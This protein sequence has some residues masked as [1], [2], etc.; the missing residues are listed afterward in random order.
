MY[1]A[2]SL[3]IP[4]FEMPDVLARVISFN[5]PHIAT[6]SPLWNW[7]LSVYLVFGIVIIPGCYAYWVYPY[8]HGPAWARGLI[9]GGFLWF[10]VEMWFMPLIGQN[11][12]DLSGSSPA[13]EILSQLVFWLLYGF[14][15]GRIAGVQ[16]VAG[17]TYGER[18]A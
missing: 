17:R 1:V 4:I 9:M 13:I 2:R 18:H 5:E 8:L 14:L 6:A 12:F 3:G 11:V 7:G 10:L 16:G 15:L